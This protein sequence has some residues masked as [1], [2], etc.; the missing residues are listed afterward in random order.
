MH[1]R[2]S[3]NIMASLTKLKKSQ[4][5][6]ALPNIKYNLCCIILSQL[7]PPTNEVWGKVIFLHLFVILFTG[8]VGLSACWDTTLP[9]SRH[10]LP[11][12][13]ADTPRADTPAADTPRSRPPWEQTI[14][15]RADPPPRE[16]TRNML[17]DTVNARVVRI[18]LE[19]NLVLVIYL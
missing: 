9:R 17:G 7:L 15:P 14:L 19:C 2:K 6:F 12:R 8:G 13:G 11:T 5:C 16:Q 3:V 10:P 4:H 1:C 18:L